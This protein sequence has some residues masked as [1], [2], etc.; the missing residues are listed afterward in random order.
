L[1]AAR[2]RLPRWLG[3]AIPRELNVDADRLSHPS[4]YAEV[5]AEAVAAG[6]RVERLAIP[7]RCRSTLE[8]AL[9]VDSGSWVEAGGD[10]R[11]R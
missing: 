9:D 7:L 8:S 4:G 5:E 1:V 3:V 11:L 2:E 10:W 6:W